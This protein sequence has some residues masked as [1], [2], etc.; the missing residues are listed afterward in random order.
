MRNSVKA[1]IDAFEGSVDFYVF[2]P[3]DP[4]IQVWQNT[5]PGLFS[6]RSELPAGLKSHIR[7][8]ESYLLAQ[9]LVYAKYH[10]EDPAVFYNQEDLWVRATEKYYQAVRPVEPYY[11]MWELPQSDR[12]EFVS[13]LPFTP[14]N[15]QVLIGWLAGLCDGD[16]YG[17]LLA[18]KFSK[19]RRVLGP[20][21]VETKIDQDPLLAGQLT[22]WDQKGSS[23]IRGNVLAIPIEQTLLYVEPIYLQADTAAY[24]E[25][26]LVVVMHGDDMAYGETFQQALDSLIASK[27]TNSKVARGSPLPHLDLFSDGQSDDLPVQ[28]NVAFERYLE[29]Q[30]EQRFEDAAI[31]LRLLQ[32]IL[33]QMVE[34]GR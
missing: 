31:E 26:R 5:L 32:E 18:Y 30:A 16:R 34:E 24:P 25:L 29:L 22:I 27:S 10:M 20:Q 4:I 6:D 17:Q 9:G 19:E 13:V 8:P 12:A 1:V 11:V 14:K 28:A 2:A 21:Q 3:D 33:Q 15:K 7:Y 23:V